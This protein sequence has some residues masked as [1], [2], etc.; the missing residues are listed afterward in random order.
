[1]SQRAGSP[2]VRL[3]HLA[4]YG[5]PYGGSFVSLVRGILTAARE[6][7]WTAEAVFPE[8]AQGRDWF[9]ELERAGISTRL[10]PTGTRR[11]LTRWLEALV[12]GN[13]A[14]LLLHTHFTTFDIPALKVARSRDRTAVIWHIHTDSVRL[15]VRV[16]SGA[17]FALLGSR[18]DRILTPA[19]SLAERIA[20]WAPRAH[21]EAVSSA[22][23]ASRFPLASPTDR[24]RARAELGLGPDRTV[25]LHFGW[26]WQ[27][28]GGELFLRTVKNLEEAGLDGFVALESRGG[29]EAERLASR[30]ELQDKVRMLEPVAHPGRLFA[31]ADVF[32]STSPAEGGIPFAII[33]AL[34]SGTPVVAT[35]IPPH[36]QAGR[37]IS[38]CRLAPSDPSSL[39][40]AIVTTLER[41]PLDAAAEAGLARSLTLERYG[42]Q[43]WVARIFAR[44]EEV[45]GQTR[46]AE[47]AAG[48]PGNR[49]A[50]T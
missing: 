36:R 43:D 20:R 44:Y 29:P 5:G 13:D 3:I 26:N 40:S 15:G 35:D 12:S 42:L 48:L 47:P 16:R 34:C 19:E 45:L 8:R 25:I 31:A 11:D 38:A 24:S 49:S 28:K 14:P 30:L 37:D 10:A 27:L 2:G 39:A 17:K 22:V 4:E 41:D 18:V 23:D 7:G 6:R 32:V 46:M 21:V 33:E 9:G 50:R 1:M